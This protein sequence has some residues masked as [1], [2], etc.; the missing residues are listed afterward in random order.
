MIR[1]PGIC[2]AAIPLRPGL[3]RRIKTVVDARGITYGQFLEELLMLAGIP[4]EDQ[5]PSEPQN[6]FVEVKSYGHSDK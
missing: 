1:K 2:D 4:P 3:K 5:S 6:N